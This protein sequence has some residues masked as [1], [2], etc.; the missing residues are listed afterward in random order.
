MTY[1]LLPFPRFLASSFF[2]FLAFGVYYRHSQVNTIRFGSS[3]LDHYNFI[4][5]ELVGRFDHWQSVIEDI[6]DEIVPRA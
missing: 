1:Y 3:E 6:P 4:L 5:H 2:S